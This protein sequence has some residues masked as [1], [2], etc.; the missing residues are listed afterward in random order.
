MSPAGRATIAAA[1]LFDGV[2]TTTLEPD[3]L[4]ADVRF[5]VWGGRSGF[6][7]EEFARRHGDFAIAGAAVGR[8]ASTTPAR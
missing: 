2:W 5:P 6:A 8:R 7:V 1:D 3:E 4:L